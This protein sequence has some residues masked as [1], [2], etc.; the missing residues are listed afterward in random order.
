MGYGLSSGHID[1]PTP[2][3]LLWRM[4][5]GESRIREGPSPGGA[6]QCFPGEKAQEIRDEGWG[7][8]SDTPEGISSWRTGCGKPQDRVHRQA[9]KQAAQ[10]AS[11]G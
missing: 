3:K 6:L 11:L 1:G 2:G 8:S 4:G 10:A 7:V 5:W 9:G